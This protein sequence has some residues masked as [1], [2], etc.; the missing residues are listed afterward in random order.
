LQEKAKEA[1]NRE[2]QGNSF[3]LVAEALSEIKPALPQFG[4]NE[5]IEEEKIPES[6]QIND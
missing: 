1:A 4:K 5:L 3:T 2:A 6:S